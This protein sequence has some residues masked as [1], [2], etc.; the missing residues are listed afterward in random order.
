MRLK[1][2]PFS[3]VIV[4]I[5]LSM[6]IVSYADSD[7]FLIGLTPSSYQVG[8]IYDFAKLTDGVTSTDSDSYAVKVLRDSGDYLEFD[9]MDSYSVDSLNLYYIGSG[10]YNFSF[11]DSEYQLIYEQTYNCSQGLLDFDSS[12]SNVRYFKVAF[13]DSNPLNC[14]VTEIELY[15]MSDN[16]APADITDLTYAVDMNDVSFTW[17]NPTDEDF[18]HVNI[19]R[20]SVL[21]NTTSAIS[22]T[23]TDL[24][25]GTEYFY[26][27][28]TV[29]TSGNESIGINRIVTT[30]AEPDLIPPSEPTDFEVVFDRFKNVLT[31]TN[32]SDAD[33]K[34]VNV[35]RDDDL[36]GSSAFQ[37]YSDLSIESDTEYTYKIASVDTS[38]NESTKVSANITTGTIEENSI[39]ILFAV[40]VESITSVITSIVSSAKNIVLSILG[41]IA[42][43]V[44]GFYLVS[45]GKKAIKRSK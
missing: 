44:G 35:Y 45:L 5:V 10:V 2:K 19:Y 22:Y 40:I 39:G 15:V 43:V 6:S 9:L 12:I 7:N 42:L 23:N 13:D 14:Y 20:D 17:T 3:F 25:K 26:Q 31:W 18:S 16:V 36:I 27:F 37:S 4:I 33:F 41:L 30:L 21:V 29:D 8:V 11:Y 32:P 28:K 38:D 1:K 34:K 24:T